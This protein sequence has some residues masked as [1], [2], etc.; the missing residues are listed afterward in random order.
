MAHI[1][2]AFHHTHPPTPLD[3]RGFRNSIEVIPSQNL[4]MS[5]VLW[6]HRMHQRSTELDRFCAT[7]TSPRY[8]VAWQEGACRLCSASATLQ[9]MLPGSTEHPTADVKMLLT[10]VS[11]LKEKA[12]VSVLLCLWWHAYCACFPLVHSSIWESYQTL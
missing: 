11:W 6:I 10:T 12:T 7:P 8:D 2:N 1:Q 9:W 3:L 5:S 4:Q